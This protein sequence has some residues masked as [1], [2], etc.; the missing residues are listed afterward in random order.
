MLHRDKLIVVVFVIV[1]F[2]SC[3]RNKNKTHVDLTSQYRK[4]SIQSI[5]DIRKYQIISQLISDTLANWEKNNIAGFRSGSCN[6]SSYTSDSLLCFNKEKDRL[7]NCILERGCKED[8]S[9]GIHFFYGVKIKEKWYFFDG[10]YIVLPREYYQKDTHTPL[11]FSKLH[12]IAMKEVFISYL[13]KDEQG[14]WKINEDFFK[15]HFEGSGWGNFNDQASED[16]FLKGRRFKTEKEFY[17][18]IYL[19]KVRNNWHHRNP[20]DS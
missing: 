10:A 13:K 18:F 9:D 4:T 8:V 6:Y 19:E 7:V 3:N 15:H 12:E 20:K 11:S 5:G 1:S 2:V 14:K 17:E 16:W